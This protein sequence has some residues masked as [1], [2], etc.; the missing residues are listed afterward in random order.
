LDPPGGPATARNLGAA[1]A[2]ATGNGLL[3]FLDADVLLA[4]TA[5]EHIHRRF[6]AER[7]LDA[8]QGV[9][10]LP[11]RN[12]NLCTAYMDELV[13]LKTAG[14]PEQTTGIVRSYCFAIRNHLWQRTGGFDK[15]ITRATVEDNDLGYRLAGLNTIIHLDRHCRVQHV[16]RYTL[17]NLLRRSFVTNSDRLKLLLR[18]RTSPGPPPTGSLVL[19]PKKTFRRFTAGFALAPVVITT[20]IAGLLLP[21]AR[22]A[23]LPVA[24]AFVLLYLPVLNGL[25]TRRGALFAMQWL[26][27]HLLDA[28]VGAAGLV[29]GTVDYIRG[30]TY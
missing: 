3:L 19:T 13:E 29:H 5:L 12:H 25:R 18:K 10:Q 7:R 23:I 27:I 16:K 20:A 9:Y 22:P 30:R 17:R 28:T 15:A 2:V 14:L 24:A 11:S 26:L 21:F 4:P 8:L 6:T 1:R